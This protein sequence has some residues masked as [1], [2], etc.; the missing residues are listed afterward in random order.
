MKVLQFAFD[1]GE[2]NLLYNPRS[3]PKK[4]VVYTGTHDN[5]TIVGW[6]DHAPKEDVALAMNTLNAEDNDA[7]AEN[8]MMSA[9]NSESDTCILTMQDLLH[10]GSEARINTPSTVGNNWQ[11]RLKSNQINSSLSHHL[12]DMTRISGRA[13]L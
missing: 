1:S 6:A 7:L 9:M 13:I 4:S 2:D 5:D 10:L 3:Y 12:L 11:W 8:M